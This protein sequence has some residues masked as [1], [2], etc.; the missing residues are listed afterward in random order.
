MRNSTLLWIA[1]TWLLVFAS[2]ISFFYA[3]RWIDTLSAPE[4]V[5]LEACKDEIGPWR[6]T[7]AI[8]RHYGFDEFQTE[9]D[10]VFTWVN[11]S[12]PLH[13]QGS[14]LLGSL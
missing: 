4:R 7:K 8:E 1:T 13:L 10:I 5:Y 6:A 11:G 9:I 3:G 14:Y 12:D 2:S